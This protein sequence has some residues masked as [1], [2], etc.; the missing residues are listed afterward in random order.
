MNVSDIL[1]TKRLGVPTASAFEVVVS[2]VKLYCTH[3][4]YITL[5]KLHSVKKFIQP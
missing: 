3:L 4:A 5:I 2:I 1:V